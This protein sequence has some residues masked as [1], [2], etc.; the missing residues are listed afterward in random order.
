MAKTDDGVS[1][2][3]A[4]RLYLMFLANPDGLRDDAE[5]KRLETEANKAKDPIDKARALAALRRAKSVDGSVFRADFVRYAKRWAEDNDIPADVLSE[6]G[7]PRTDLVEAGLVTG[8]PRR[9]RPPRATTSGTTKTRAPQVRLE[10]ITAFVR[11]LKGTFVLSDIQKDA[12]GSPMTIRK[13]VD[14]LVSA[15]EVEKLG[16]QENWNGRGRAPIVYRRKP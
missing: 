13:A 9:G 11:E 5:I 16:P 12:G 10:T 4:V 6:M 3:G 14:G 8:G 2:E 1:P 7:V 15:G